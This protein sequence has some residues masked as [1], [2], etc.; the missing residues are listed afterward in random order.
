MCVLGNLLAAGILIPVSPRVYAASRAAINNAPWRHVHTHCWRKTDAAP[1]A[2][3]DTLKYFPSA[4]RRLLRDSRC[5]LRLF[6][7]T[8]HALAIILPPPECHSSRR[9]MRESLY[10]NG[11]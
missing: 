9:R 2:A 6:F 8:L 11:L 5:L 3:A 1:A 7:G 4:E 10:I